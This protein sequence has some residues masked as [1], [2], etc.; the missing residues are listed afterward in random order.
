M[1]VD[2]KRIPNI[3]LRKTVEKLKNNKMPD[4]LIIEQILKFDDL[5]E[6][7]QLIDYLN[8]LKNRKSAQTQRK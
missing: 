3:V 2:G 6:R 4:K 1:I 5:A 8:D 7:G